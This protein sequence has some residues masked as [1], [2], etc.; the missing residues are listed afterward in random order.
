MTLLIVAERPDTI[1]ALS[2]INELEEHL[3]PLYPSESRHGYSVEK[4]IRE[5]VAFFVMRYNE[6]LAGCGGVK[7]YPDEYAEVKR[8]Y[9]RPTYRGMGFAKRMLEH[10]ESV[11]RQQAIPLLRLETGIHQIEAI[12]L[13]ERVGFQRVGPFGEYRLDPLSIFYEKKIA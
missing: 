1:D 4:L 9:V 3:S 8:M 10:L 11:A 7:I 12:G 2:L 6:E 5:E 13:Y